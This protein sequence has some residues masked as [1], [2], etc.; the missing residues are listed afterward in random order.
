MTDPRTIAIEAVTEDLAAIEH[1][2]WMAWASTIAMN[3]AIS[4]ERLARWEKSMVPYADLPDEVKEQDRE[5]ARKVLASPRLASLLL[6]GAAVEA[7]PKGRSWNICHHVVD[8]HYS[9]Q[10]LDRSAGRNDQHGHAPT[11][12]EAIAA[13]LGDGR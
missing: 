3:E 2:Q 6:T 5:W 1:E 8:D 4:P 11:L 9:V 12:H 10:T 7:L 13:A